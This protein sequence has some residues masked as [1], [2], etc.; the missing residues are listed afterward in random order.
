MAQT[1]Q[2]TYALGGKDEDY[3]LRNEVLHLDCPGDQIESCQW[4]QVGNLQIARSK[5]VSIALPESHD[6]CN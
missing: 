6:I 1:S 3:N 5:H 2:G 4:K